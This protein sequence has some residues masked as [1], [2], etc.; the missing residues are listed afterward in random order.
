MIP[1]IDLGPPERDRP[2]VVDRGGETGQVTTKSSASRQVSW[3][4]THEFLQAL[5]SQA[6]SGP[7][8]WPGTPAWCALADGDPR[9]LLAL[10]EFGVHHALRVET[11]QEAH[12]GASR[13][14]AAAADWSAVARDRLRH[15]RALKDGAYIPRVVL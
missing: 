11:A 10:A 2:P 9:K 6:N 15:H 5:V 12:A 13:A 4:S 7:L 8:P 1:G 3:W 14:I